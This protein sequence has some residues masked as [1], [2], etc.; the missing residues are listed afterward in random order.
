[1][2]AS[3]SSLTTLGVGSKLLRM[4]LLNRRDE[5]LIMAEAG[6]D[7]Q[8]SHATQAT[9]QAGCFHESK[10][11]VRQSLEIARDSVDWTSERQRQL[12]RVLTFNGSTL[13]EEVRSDVQPAAVPIVKL[14]I[15]CDRL[16]KAALYHGASCAR[17]VAAAEE[18]QAVL[19]S[20]R[21]AQLRPG[22]LLNQAAILQ[23]ARCLGWL[24]RVETS[25]GDLPAFQGLSGALVGLAAKQS[26]RLHRRTDTD[27]VDATLVLKG[28]L[29]SVGGLKAFRARTG[30]SPGFAL[31]AIE[32]AIRKQPDLDLAEEL[33]AEAEWAEAD[34]HE[35]PHCLIGQP[36]MR[37]FWRRCFGRQEEVTWDVF[38]ARFPKDVSRRA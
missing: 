19:L 10:M 33:A 37:L 23:E 25:Q 31:H 24:G 3:Q 6:P 5:L 27:A 13:V 38:W 29:A 16:G 17:F 4:Q 32:P 22:A 12:V 34:D 18:L 11:R 26:I 21:A 36:E 8:R 15:D 2:A 35:R 1:M 28:K 14:L 7:S 20:R 30:H 9:E